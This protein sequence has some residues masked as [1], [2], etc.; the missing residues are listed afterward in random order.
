M[1]VLRSE[2][3]VALFHEWQDIV[4]YPL[5]GERVRSRQD[6]LDTSQALDPRD[7][8]YTPGC[9]EGALLSR[10][11][12]LSNMLHSDDIFE[13]MEIGDYGAVTFWTRDRVY[14]LWSHEPGG[15]RFKAVR[16][17]PPSDPAV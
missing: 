12:L 14:Q 7:R 8:R 13:V 16:R 5:D 1:T 15:E 9:A 2:A 11:Y 10:S 3:N 17:H 4:V 6:R